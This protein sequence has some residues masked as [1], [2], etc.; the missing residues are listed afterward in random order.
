MTSLPPSS[1]PPA[2]GAQR[3]RLLYLDLLRFIAI[4]ANPVVHSTGPLTLSADKFERLLSLVYLA[5]GM[6]TIPWLLM[7]SGAL[8]LANTRPMSIST[9]YR[10]RLLK[11]VIPLVAWSVFYYTFDIHPNDSVLTIA[12]TFLK[13]FLTLTW[14]GPLWFLYMIAA[15]YLMLPFL[16]PAFAGDTLKLSLVCVAIILG[17]HTLDFLVHL[18]F[19]QPLNQTFTGTI[20]SY[21][22]AYFILGNVL[23][24]V[25]PKIPGGCATLAIVFLLCA[26]VMAFGEFLAKTSDFAQPDIFCAFQN[27]LLAIMGACGFLFFKNWNPSFPRPIARLVLW[28]SSVSYGVYLSHMVI[29]KLLSGEIPL[30]FQPG[31]GLDCYTISPLVGPTLCGVATFIVAAP[32]I[33]LM[34]RIPVLRWMVP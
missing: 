33:A 2:P 29:L 32:L 11:I 6:T 9:L 20:F 14:S 25:K 8:L 13:G 22:V 24:R 16:R 27:P 26:A 30:F 19:R 7:V 3:E 31:H 10:K 18:A 1:A 17:T 15:I 34:K 21:F 12:A 28:L 4:F 23:I 5:V